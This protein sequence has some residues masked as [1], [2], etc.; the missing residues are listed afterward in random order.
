[1]KA[2][3]IYKGTGFLPGVPARDLTEEEY[4]AGVE[5]HGAEAMEQLYRVTAK[6]KKEAN[7]ARS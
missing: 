1:M 2:Y 4:K 3:A 6:K 7:D 5:A